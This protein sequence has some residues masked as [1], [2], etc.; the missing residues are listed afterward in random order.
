MNKK[1][2][3][4]GS[5]LLIGI[6]ISFSIAT[7]AAYLADADSARNAVTVGGN[8]I[9]IDEI[10]EPEPIMPDETIVKKVRIKNTGPNACYV[11]VMAVFSDSDLGKYTQVDWNLKDWIYNAQDGYY[12]YPS[13]IEH[14]ESTSWLFTSLRFSEDL[15]QEMIKDTDLIVYAESYQA[16]GFENYELAWKDFQIN[17]NH[18]EGD[19]K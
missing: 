16:E 6:C 1:R 3:I 13:I 19:N 9:E 17:K 11:R 14:D 7:I 15:P 5:L 10:F 18:G 12:Y 2:T 8:R 4:I